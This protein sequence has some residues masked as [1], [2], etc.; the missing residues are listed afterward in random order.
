VIRGKNLG[1]EERGIGAFIGKRA[2]GLMK[3]KKKIEPMHVVKEL[4]PGRQT[5]TPA[6]LEGRA[7]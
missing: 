6:Q 3:R 7:V 4:P 5:D 2:R 1:R